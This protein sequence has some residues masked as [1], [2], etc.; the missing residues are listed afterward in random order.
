MKKIHI[1]LFI[2]TISTQLMVGQNL[3]RANHLF[4]TRAYLDAA[5]LFL[6]ETPKNQEIYEKLGDCYY[7]NT[8]MN[9]AAQW[10]KKLLQ[11]YEAKVSPTYFYRYS[12]ALKGIKNYKEA[13][14][15]F[16]KYNKQQQLTSS[17]NIQTIPFFEELNT[18]IKTQYN[19]QKLAVNSKGSDFGVS[20]YNNKIVFA[21]TRTQGKLY[22]WNKQPYLDL[23]EATINDLGEASNVT[24]L[25]NTIN[26]KMHESNAVFTKDGK[27]MYFTRNNFLKGKKGKDGKKVTHLKIYKA[28]LIND[29]WKNITELPFNSDQYSVE[30]PAL[31]TNEKQLY[32]SSDMPGT[33]GSFDLFVVDINNGNFGTPKNLG[34]TINTKQRE[35]FPFISSNNTLYFASNG[36]FGLG[37]LD[38]FKSTITN[39]KFSKPSNLSDKINSSLDDFS[40]VI[41]DELGIGYLSSNRT[42][43]A[44]DDDIY[45][46]TKK[47]RYFVSG[48]VQNKNNLELLPGASVTLLSDTA[49][50]ISDIVVGMNA[51]YSLEIEKNK[52]Y[53]LKATQKLYL[54]YEVIFST[55]SQGN[56]N[57]N[58][59]LL[60]ELYTDVDKEIVDKD[61]KTQIEINAIYFDFNKWNITSSAAFELD[62]IVAIMKKYPDMVIE[63]GA[64]TDCRGTDD[65]NL[66]LS[67]KRATSVQTY[68][69]S[70]G[71]SSANIKSVGYGETQP[72][73][74]CITDDMCKEEEYNINRRCEFVIVN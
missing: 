37:G 38:I 4:E 31:S 56:I 9:K 12:Q 8:K 3:R 23:F 20:F 19:I 1:A 29:K 24:A 33:I 51:F 43:G 34:A 42:G 6:N 32:F 55:D 74:H 64:H 66:K 57:K 25:P 30:H 27:T 7:F 10:Y 52:T 45:R 21:S 67:K 11:T 71:I 40:F 65:Y 61:G 50:L 14:Q 39:Q 18:S 22:N 60:L 70:K 15:W 53:K 16:Q 63:I 35:Q 5:E 28:E 72:L 2:L 58:I 36:H 41:N 26:T 62:N 46:F 49:T 13:D 73:N 48:L 44:G 47:E 59:Q 54:P 69:E 17:E 68:L